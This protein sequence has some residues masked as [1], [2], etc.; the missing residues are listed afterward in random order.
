MVIPERK[1]LF[2]I[3]DTALFYTLSIAPVVLVPLYFLGGTSSDSLPTF[4]LILQIVCVAI[5]SCTSLSFFGLIFYGSPSRENENAVDLFL[6]KGWPGHHK[7]IVTFVSYGKNKE[8]IKKSILS[9]SKLLLDHRIP[10]HIEVLLE[11]DLRKYL[12]NI[13]NLEVL[14]VPPNYQT[15]EGSMFKARALHYG[16]ECRK[17]RV[18]DFNTTW[19]LHCDEESIVTREA[20]SGIASFVDNPSN[21]NTIGQGEIQYNSSGY[22][23]SVLIAALDSI[24]TGDDL[25]RFRFQYKF[26]NDSIIGVHGSFLIVPA[27]LENRVGFD[28]GPA[29]SL[30]EDSYFAFFAAMKGAKFGWVNGYIQEQSPFT[31]RDIFKQRRRWLNG[32]ANLCLDR[33]VNIKRRLLLFFSLLCWRLSWVCTFL[34]LP[35]MFL[36]IPHSAPL[37]V[38]SAIFS[39]C[40]IGLYLV[41]AYRNILTQQ[42]PPLRKIILFLKVCS[43]IPVAVFVETAMVAYAVFCP[44][45]QFYIVRKDSA[46]A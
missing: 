33:R 17:K 8:T 14:V 6:E 10:H 7:L 2:F 32:I 29:A 11:I 9:A 43:L 12:E 34:T 20:L 42:T 13:P 41:G 3:F 36:L 16:V 30:T 39:G 31:L 5:L 21:V 25:G 4:Y 19:I 18:T 1:T 27:E 24:R 45:K 23:N 40:A 38:F 35:R 22:A 28:H 15:S 44:S 26:L 37:R 46:T